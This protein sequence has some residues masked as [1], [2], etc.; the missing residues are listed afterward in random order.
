MIIFYDS[1]VHKKKILILVV[2]R[3]GIEFSNSSMRSSASVSDSHIEVRVVS[4]FF[5]DLAGKACDF[6]YRPEEFVLSFI[7]AYQK[8]R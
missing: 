7:V 4:D 2:M 6:S 8:S 3:M 1:V 5:A